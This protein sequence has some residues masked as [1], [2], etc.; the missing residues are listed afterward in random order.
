MIK[1]SIVSFILILVLAGCKKNL[2]DKNEVWKFEPG[3]AY[4]KF[5]H[6]YTSLFPSTAGPANGPTVDY[7][8]NGAKV[9]ALNTTGAGL[10]YNS[11]FPVLS[12]QY[13]SVVPGSLTISA[14]LNRPVGTAPQPNDVVANSSFTL[15]ASKY[16]TAF[17]V[18]TMPFPSSTSPNLVLVQDNVEKAKSGFFKIRFAHM[19]PT[20]DTL[21]MISKNSQ[22]VIAGNLTFK[23]VSDFMEMPLLSRNDTMQLRKKGTTA[24]LATQTGAFFPSNERV[25]TFWCRGL[26]GSTT[27]TRARSIGSYTNL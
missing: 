17:L 19:I 1:N 4:I 12:G 16:Y 26:Y 9:S 24:I 20:T 14:V 11:L 25:Y 8:V 10:A 27:G 13:I 3:N 6:A 23:K 5:V 15:D 22:T 21:E 2:L 7:I 18:D